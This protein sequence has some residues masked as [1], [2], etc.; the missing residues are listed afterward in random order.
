MFDSNDFHSY[1]INIK[2]LI[3]TKVRSMILRSLQL[4]FEACDIYNPVSVVLKKFGVFFL[5]EIDNTSTTP[6]KFN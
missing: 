3:L 4:F 5:V 6:S 1:D 2:I